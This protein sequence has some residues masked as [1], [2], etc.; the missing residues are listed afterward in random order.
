MIAQEIA[1]STVAGRVNRKS[2]IVA[3]GLILVVALVAYGHLWRPHYAPYSD[4]SD[5]IALHLGMKWAAYQSL[6]A[7]HG[8]PF[9]KDDLLGGVPP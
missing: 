2:G 5:L 7:G 6:W 1:P 9:W 8:L 4:C 3:L